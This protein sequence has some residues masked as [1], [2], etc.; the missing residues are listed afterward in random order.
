MYFHFLNILY[1]FIYIFLKMEVMKEKKNCL[2]FG[3]YTK[4]RFV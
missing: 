3:T 4:L 2:F 1:M